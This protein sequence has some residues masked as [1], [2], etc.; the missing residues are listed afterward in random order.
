MNFTDWFWEI[1]EF[2][3]TV[4]MYRCVIHCTDFVV[5][6]NE[7]WQSRLDICLFFKWLYFLLKY[8]ALYGIF[9]HRSYSSNYSKLHVFHSKHSY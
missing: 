7:K 5:L 2:M 4:Y 8:T 3:C 1:E 9:Q 6:L